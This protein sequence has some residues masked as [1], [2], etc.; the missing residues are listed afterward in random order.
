MKAIH[1]LIQSIKPHFEDGGKLSRFW[2]VFDSLETFAFTPGH[3]T[4]SGA[5]LR[6]SIDLK[7]TMFLVIV[8]MVPCPV[9]YTHLR[10]HET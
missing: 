10:A 2:V 5:H 6:D 8:A 9:S 1:N 4:S 7:R 3:V